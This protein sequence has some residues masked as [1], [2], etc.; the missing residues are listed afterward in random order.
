MN[1]FDA[2]NV[3]KPGR[4]NNTFVRFYLTSVDAIC[5]KE[6]VPPVTNMKVESATV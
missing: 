4:G 3:E 6:L 1:V 5:G 2:R